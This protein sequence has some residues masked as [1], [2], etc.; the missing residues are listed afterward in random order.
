[1]DAFTALNI[2]KTIKELA[3]SQK[4][5]VLMTIHQPRTDILNLLDKIFLLSMGKCVWFGPNKSALEHFAELGYSIPDNT[6][7]SDF[8]MDLTTFDQRT[9]E[10]ILTSTGKIKMFVSEFEKNLEIIQVVKELKINF[11]GFNN[12]SIRFHSTI[13]N[14]FMVLCD[15]YFK[16]AVCDKAVLFAIL[17]QNVLL[18]IIVG[19]I[20]FQL[21]N[22][23]LF[24]HKIK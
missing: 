23:P 4:K 11:E 16:D 14:E 13:S 9:D 8:Y 17:M 3:V 18:L 5:I 1:L 6:N 22:I 24:V 2:I 7:A 15:R 21:D 10:L 20:F 19:F 12:D